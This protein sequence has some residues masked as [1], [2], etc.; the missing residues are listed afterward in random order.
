MKK[1]LNRKSNS[2]GP[3]R[4]TPRT[5][6]T[7][8]GAQQYVR[9]N[10]YDERT[11]SLNRAEDAALKARNFEALNKLGAASAARASRETTAIVGTKKA[12]TN[13]SVK[14]YNNQE[15]RR[16]SKPKNK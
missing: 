13:R 5:Y 1:P 16:M 4:P 2:M 8:N 7:A 15:K 14:M 10:T 6:K 11:K 3:K 9:G 12:N